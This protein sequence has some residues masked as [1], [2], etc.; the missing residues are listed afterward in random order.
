MPAVQATAAAVKP[1]TR[2]GRPQARKDGKKS[3]T[4]GIELSEELHEVLS[5]RAAQN[6]TSIRAE[7]LKILK[8]AL[9]P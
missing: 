7:V 5:V 2:P 6:G 3:R 9:L 4:C 8:A 1:A